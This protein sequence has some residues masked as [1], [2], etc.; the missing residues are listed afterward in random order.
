MCAQVVYAESPA[1]MGFVA[2]SEEFGHMAKVAQ[3][4][5][6]WSGGEHEKRL[7]AH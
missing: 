1:E 2:P 7:W 3:P 6:Y 5:V 4:I